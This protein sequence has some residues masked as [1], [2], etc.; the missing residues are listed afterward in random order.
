MAPRVAGS[1]EIHEFGFR[2]T[3]EAFLKI[4]VR[5]AIDAIVGSAATG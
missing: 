4:F 1:I 5:L 2:G 3:K